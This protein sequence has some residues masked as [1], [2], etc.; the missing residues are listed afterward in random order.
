MLITNQPNRTME[1]AIRER[2][3]DE[4]NLDIASGYF[5]IKTLE[6][7]RDPLLAKAKK[8]CTV[9]LLNGLAAWEGLSQGQQIELGNMDTELRSISSQNGVFFCSTRRYHGKIYSFHD[10]NQR[11]TFI[12][13]SNFSPTGLNSNLEANFYSEDLSFNSEIE[14]FLE[15]LFSDATPYKTADLFVKG[16]SNTSRKQIAQTVELIEEPPENIETMPISFKIPIRIHEKS[17]INVTFGAGRLNRRTG[18]YK[19][20]PYYEAELTMPKEMFQSSCDIASYIDTKKLLKSEFKAR[21][22]SGKCFGV[23][24]SPKNKGQNLEESGGDFMSSTREL[25]GQ[26]IKDKL[27][28]AGCMTY[29]DFVSDSTLDDYGQNELTITMYGDNHMY[30]KF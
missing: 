23:N 3:D 24:F 5:G 17:S 6:K 21:T 20:R 1:D 16:I 10:H 30:I 14:Q 29:G 25:L 15:F 27:I 12:G 8:G 11:R 13:S 2:F 19:P 26:Y 4:H 9:R 18:V 7:F 22:D 28:D